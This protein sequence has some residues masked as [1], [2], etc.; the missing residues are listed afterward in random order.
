MKLNL[1]TAFRKSIVVIL[2]LVCSVLLFYKIEEQSFVWKEN[3]TLLSVN[4]QAVEKEW[5]GISNRPAPKHSGCDIS[6]TSDTDKMESIKRDIH[7]WSTKRDTYMIDHRAK[8][9]KSFSLFVYDYKKMKVLRT[10]EWENPE[11]EYGIDDERGT[12]AQVSTDGKFWYTTDKLWNYEEKANKTLPSLQEADRQCKKVLDF[13]GFSYAERDNLKMQGTFE[14]DMGEEGVYK[15]KT[16]V[17]FY[18]KKV[19]G[20]PTFNNGYYFEQDR[21]GITDFEYQT[22]GISYLLIAEDEI[23]K[24]MHPKDMI[25]PKKV[26]KR[27]EKKVRE[28]IS[29]EMYKNYSVEDF[30]L[31]YAYQDIVERGEQ[32]D[33]WVGKFVPGWI[34]HINL[35]KYDFE[36]QKWEEEEVYY[37]YPLDG[38][39]EYMLDGYTWG[40]GFENTR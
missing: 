21:D 37:F 32:F 1:K 15:P 16:N 36:V 12:R 31:A 35:E 14:Y 26:V 3:Q 28:S 29:S 11:Y 33:E 39:K 34:L 40:G 2:L 19:E 27:F 4:Q 5:R 9:E 17:L 20:I 22:A 8:L 30:Y 6:Y 10:P 38:T 13:F 25:T 23:L 7:I 24:N 18:E